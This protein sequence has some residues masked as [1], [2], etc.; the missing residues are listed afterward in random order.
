MNWFY[1]YQGQRAGP[2][3]DEEFARLVGEGTVGETTLVWHGGMPDWMPYVQARATVPAPPTAAP[4]ANNGNF[5]LAPAPTG[6]YQAQCS[7]CGRVFPADE[8]IRL[9][10]FNVCAECKP[11]LLQKI[12]QGMSPAQG[13]W[14]ML[15]ARFGGFW[16]RWGAIVLDVLIM[17]PLLVVVWFAGM[18]AIPTA[19]VYS[20]GDSLLPSMLFQLLYYGLIAAYEIFFVGRFAATPGKMIC[21]L[22]VVRSDGSPVTYGRATGR[23]FARFL[24]KFTLYIGYLIAAFDDQKRALHDHVCDTRVVYKE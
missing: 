23:F 3:N 6:A 21:G 24:T 22:R 18:Y 13:A 14:G 8:V 12:R 2:V 15:P 7:Q 19:A 1:A 5:P 17:S 4:A 16:I 10:G 20:P 11:L 9:E